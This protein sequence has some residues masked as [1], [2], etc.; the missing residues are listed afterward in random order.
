MGKYIVP[1][2]DSG[3]GHAMKTLNNYVLVR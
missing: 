2:G 3:A 1:M